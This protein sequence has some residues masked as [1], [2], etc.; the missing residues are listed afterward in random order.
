M[1]TADTIATISSAA[2]RALHGLASPLFALIRGR[3]VRLG[4]RY[5]PER[6]YMRGPGPKWHAKH[7]RPQTGGSDGDRVQAGQGR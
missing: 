4:H 7:D 5:H 6:Y 2:V 1:T 3:M